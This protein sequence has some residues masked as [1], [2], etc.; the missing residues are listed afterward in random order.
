MRYDDGSPI[1]RSYG[2]AGTGETIYITADGTHWL[3]DICVPPPDDRSATTGT[4]LGYIA[5]NRIYHGRP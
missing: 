4:R 1:M 3:H 2:G 5:G